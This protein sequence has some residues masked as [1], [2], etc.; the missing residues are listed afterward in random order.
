MAG[1]QV[2]G[3]G[4][5]WLAFAMISVASWGCYGVLLHTGQ[6]SMADPE[7]G[8]YKAFLFVGVAY[9]LVAVIG[10][11]I[12]LKL[13]GS[14]FSFTSKGMVWSTIAG[15]AGAAGAAARDHGRA[16]VALRIRRAGDVWCARRHARC[17]RRFRVAGRR[18]RVP[19]SQLGILAGRLV[20]DRSGPQ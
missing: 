13:N 8:R 18:P 19:R 17:G 7:N 16:R 11:L 2:T 4:F 10:S 1:E 15:V 5:M 6:I 14:D 3:P 12:I 20:I 9:V